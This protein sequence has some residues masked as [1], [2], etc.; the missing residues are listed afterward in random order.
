[1]TNPPDDRD[2][3]G[4]L[5]LGSGSPRRADLLRQLGL[6]FEVL[7]PAIDETPA[8]GESPADYVARMA[9]TKVDAVRKIA[10]ADRLLLCADTTVTLDGAILG[11]P[12]DRA[13]CV[14]MLMAL[15]DTSHQ[16]LT[17]VAAADERHATEAVVETIVTFRPLTLE[18]CNDYWLT[19]EPA[20]KA[21]G[22]GIQGMGAVLV[23][24]ISGSYSNVVGLPL[25]ET[26]MML[27]EFGVDCL[28]RRGE[29]A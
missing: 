21:G 9:S 18:E 25:T 4:P 1:M 23:Q 3:A 22:Y 7:P 16:V 27:R 6:R 14:E 15:S 29:S 10:G 20:D 8:D 19:G 12:S 17:G 2:T 5:V 11:K 24:S 13:D 26:A 28:K